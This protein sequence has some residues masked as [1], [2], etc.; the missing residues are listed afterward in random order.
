MAQVFKGLTGNIDAV[1]TPFHSATCGVTL[2]T[3]GGKEYLITGRNLVV[4]CTK[5]A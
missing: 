5:I 2:D 3:D 4:K 1:Y